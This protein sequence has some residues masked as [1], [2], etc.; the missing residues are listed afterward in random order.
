MSIA[1]KVWHQLN[2]EHD[3][4]ARCNIPLVEAGEIYYRQQALKATV[5]VQLKLTSFHEIRSGS[6]CVIP[7]NL[8]AKITQFRRI[9]KN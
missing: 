1:R 9:K 8:A 3:H 5:L 6:T 4:V 2:R 7:C